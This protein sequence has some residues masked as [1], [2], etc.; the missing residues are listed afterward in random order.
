MIF[1]NQV[2][3]VLGAQGPPAPGPG[4]T[5]HYE[6]EAL[7][8]GGATICDRMTGRFSGDVLQFM[9]FGEIV[10]SFMELRGLSVCTLYC[11]IYR[12]YADGSEVGTGYSILDI[13]YHR[14]KVLAPVNRTADEF[15]AGS[16]LYPYKLVCVYGRSNFLLHYYADEAGTITVNRTFADGTTDSLT[17]SASVGQSYAVINRGTSSGGAAGIHAHV[18]F[19]YR[20]MDIYFLKAEVKE[21]FIFRN[22]YNV[23]EYVAIPAALSSEPKT[24]FEEAQQDGVLQ[25]YDIEQQLSLELKSASIPSVL[26]NQL[27]AMCRAK[28]VM[29]DVNEAMPTTVATARPVIIEEYKLP[30]STAPGSKLTVELKFKYCDTE[31]NDVVLIQ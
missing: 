4:D 3:S 19:G 1:L 22:V 28:S 2:E 18:E 29:Y 27:L 5:F 10:R 21:T 24:E 13:L 8:N 6:L 12:V 31:M 9:G 30:K 26:Y 20:Q 11:N 23:E 16:F 17:I 15:L 25:R 14:G 7:Y